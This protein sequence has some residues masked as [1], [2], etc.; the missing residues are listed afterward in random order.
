MLENA[1]PP[2]SRLGMCRWTYRFIIGLT[3]CFM[4]IRSPKSCIVDPSY[5]SVT[6][7]STS[8]VHS[9]IRHLPIRGFLSRCLPAYDRE[10]TKSVCGRLYDRREDL[11]TSAGMGRIMTVNWSVWG[12]F[13]FAA[14]APAL[15]LEATPM[16][17]SSSFLEGLRSFQHTCRLCS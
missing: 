6:C 11:Q 9:L 7:F 14:V 8:I 13:N 10:V 17:K 15:I 12:I 5:P 2:P 4:H 16:T 1:Y 3:Q